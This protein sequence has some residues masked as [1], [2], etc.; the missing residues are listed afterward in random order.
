MDS[1]DKF[2][3][4]QLPPI[5]CFMSLLKHLTKD[6]NKLQNHQLNELKSDYNHAQNVFTKFECVD[7]QYYLELYMMQDIYLLTCSFE[8]FRDLSL[9]HFKLDPVHY[10]TLPSLAWDAMLKK[11]CIKN[12]KLQLFTEDEINI[13]LIMEQAKIGGISTIGSK[14]YSKANNRYLKDYDE[15]LPSTFINV[16]DINGLYSWGMSQKLPYGEFRSEYIKNPE[17]ITPLKKLL[18]N[19]DGDDGAFVVVDVNLPRKFDKDQDDYPCF[20][21]NS[22]ITFNDLSP[23]TQE[24]LTSLNKDKKISRKEIST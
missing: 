20:P 7:L 21:S 6:I 16:F 12:F 1:F 5:H 23:T 13:Y 11:V 3:E 22:D 19:V 8:K 18:E 14:R 24:D 2:K 9:N 4:T 10:H 17:N 15:T